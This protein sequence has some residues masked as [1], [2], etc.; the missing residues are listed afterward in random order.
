[1][2]ETI[3]KYVDKAALEHLIEKLGVREDQKDATV[4]ASAKT[5]ANGLADNT[6]LLVKRLNS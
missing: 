6:I 2:A 5:Y 3:K 4:L 1:M